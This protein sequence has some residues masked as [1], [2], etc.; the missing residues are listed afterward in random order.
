[1]NNNILFL[2]GQYLTTYDDF[3]RV[4]KLACTQNDNVT[5]LLRSELCAVV[6]DE[7]LGD[8]LSTIGIDFDSDSVF[9]EDVSHLTDSTLFELIALEVS[10]KNESTSS[11]NWRDFIE[12]SDIY[13]L[14]WNNKFTVVENRNILQR[15][16]NPLTKPTIS[17][18][19]KIIKNVNDVIWIN[20][21]VDGKLSGDFS[22]FPL[23]DQGDIFE[24]S[25]S[26]HFKN[27]IKIV[28]CM[29]KPSDSKSFD[30]SDILFEMSNS[31][32]LGMD[33]LLA[34]DDL[35]NHYKKNADR[36]YIKPDPFHRNIVKN[37]LVPCADYGYYLAMEECA[38]YFAAIGETETAQDYFNKW[39]VINGSANYYKDFQTL[40]KQA[41]HNGYPIS[42][43]TD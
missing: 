27:N 2:G 39:E 17:L 34:L 40:F 30:E 3:L 38:L 26:G 42:H 31:E 12:L 23:K 22:K 32:K 1:M 28:C 43:L 33:T 4:V 41:L 29:S 15:C 36:A 20:T 35:Q 6:R 25:F 13:S 11:L 14:E 18:N 5:M 16:I 24:Y 8:W 37:V 21:I 10:I 9:Y 7:V 19:I